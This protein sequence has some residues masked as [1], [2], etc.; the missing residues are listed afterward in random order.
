MRSC[1]FGRRPPPHSD[2]SICDHR[3]RERVG[4]DRGRALVQLPCTIQQSRRHSPHACQRHG[5]DLQRMRFDDIEG[6]PPQGVGGRRE[7]PSRQGCQRAGRTARYNYHHET[8]R[9]QISC[10]TLGANSRAKTFWTPGGSFQVVIPTSVQVHDSYWCGLTGTAREADARISTLF[11]ELLHFNG[12]NEDDN[13][14]RNT[15][16]RHELERTYACESLCFGF[17]PPTRCSCAVCLETKS[18]DAKCKSLGSCATTE[19]VQSDPDNCG[20]C[21]NKCTAC[22]NCTA[23]TCG[24]TPGPTVCGTSCCNGPCAPGGNGCCPPQRVCDKE[25]CTPEQTCKTRL[26]GS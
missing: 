11:H 7:M 1:P 13:N 2:T 16:Q 22:Q 21:G 24:P 6:N 14:E 20:S 5:N 26:D 4:H 10:A 8:G 23:G 18:C 3:R 9:V 25:C 17:P 15:A 12:P 19:D